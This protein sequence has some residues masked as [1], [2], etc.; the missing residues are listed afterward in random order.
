M[1]IQYQKYDLGQTLE[2]G[3]LNSCVKQLET[4]L[5]KG[6]MKNFNNWYFNNYKSCM[7][8]RVVFKHIPATSTFTDEISRKWIATRD[9]GKEIPKAFG[10]FTLKEL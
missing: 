2:R 8:N 6:K 10:Q 5:Y 4:R 9:G 1:G 7:G 3:K